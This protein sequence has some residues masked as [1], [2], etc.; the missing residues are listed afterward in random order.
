MRPSL[1]RHFQQL[2]ERSDILFV[3]V[4]NDPLCNGGKL[5][6]TTDVAVSGITK[7]RIS[8]AAV[9]SYCSLIPNRFIVIAG[10]G[11]SGGPNEI[12]GC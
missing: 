12:L 9:I 10:K 5:H 4:H 7:R 1:S 3:G 8:A 2:D 6:I 11:G